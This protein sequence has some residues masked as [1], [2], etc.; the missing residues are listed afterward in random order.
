MRDEAN[1]P[2][3]QRALLTWIRRAGL[4]EPVSEYAF[5]KV[6]GWLFDAAYVDQYLAIEID[7]GVY[8]GG[9]HVRPKGYEGD[10]EKINEAQAQGWRVLRITPQ[11]LERDPERCLDWIARCLRG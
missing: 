11:M 2:A 3:G 6:R 8:S 10:C 5:D 4:P 7:G 9:R 1:L